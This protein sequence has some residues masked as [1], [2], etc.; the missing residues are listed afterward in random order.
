MQALINLIK[1]EA[2]GGVLLLTATVLALVFG[3][4]GI[5]SHF[6]NEILSSQFVIGF[7]G[8][9]LAKPLITWVNDGLMVVFFFVVGLELK[10]EVKEGALREKSQIVLPLVGAL[11]GVTLPA[12][13]FWAFNHGDE[14]A[15]RGWA[16]PT[17]TDIA[18]ALGILA[19]LGAKRVPAGLK[20]FL[21]T[22]AVIDDLCAIII[23][24]LFYT[25]QLSLVSMGL[26]ALCL[27]ALGVLHH[28]RVPKKSLYLFFTFL[29]WLSVLNSGVHA[30]IAGVLAAFC[31]P[32]RDMHGKHMLNE[33]L[34]DLSSVTTYFILPVFAF[35]NAGVSLAGVSISQLVNS[36]SS[37]I[38]FGLL[39]GKQLGVFI[40]SLI[41]IRL[42]FAKLPAGTTWIQF[43][44]VCILTG[45]GFT[46]SLFVDSLAYHESKEFFHADKLAVLAA[47]LAS[48]VLGAIY[49]L[50]YHKAKAGSNLK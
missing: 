44:G 15:L 10:R 13:I 32:T 8:H 12:V 43:Y 38:F 39:A 35:V 2:F 50:V 30:T 33:L 16:I 26:A 28:F 42:G 6:Y 49:L 9:D 4:S 7:R 40:F 31:I 22:L 34:A 23:I 37:G 48:G 27:G 18:F 11:G 17:A 46:M 19:L 1:H 45:I 41:F 24:A 5:L 14:F 25:G 29:L 3:N 20:V 21:M 36:V 47:S